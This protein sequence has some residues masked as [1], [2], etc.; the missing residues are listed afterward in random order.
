M[1]ELHKNL[2]SSCAYACIFKY[3]KLVLFTMQ[4]RKA[5]CSD[6]IIDKRTDFPLYS[7]KRR[8]QPNTRKEQDEWLIDSVYFYIQQLTVPNNSVYQGVCVNVCLESYCHDRLDMLESCWVLILFTAMPNTSSKRSVFHVSME[9]YSCFLSDVLLFFLFPQ[10][11][12]LL[13]TSVN[14]EIKMHIYITI[15]K[16]FHTNYLCLNVSAN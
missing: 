2:T 8:K 5:C 3:N 1:E 13:L 6:L 11:L 9:V 4:L 7:A 10:T 12:S 15:C 14:I 16:I